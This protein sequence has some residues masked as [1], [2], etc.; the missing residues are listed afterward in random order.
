VAIGSIRA[1]ALFRS[2]RA[3]VFCLQ[4]ACLLPGA[5]HAGRE[6]VL[7]DRI[8]AQIDLLNRA[9]ARCQQRIDNDELDECD[10]NITWERRSV[11]LGEARTIARELAGSLRTH[12][13]VVKSFIRRIDTASLS[14]QTRTRAENLFAR[15]SNLG[16]TENPATAAPSAGD[17][18]MWSRVKA[19]AT[20]KAGRV[21]QWQ[22]GELETEFGNEFGILGTVG[23]AGAPLQ[24]SPGL[25]GSAPVDAV[26]FTYMVKGRPNKV[27]LPVLLAVHNR[28]CA[29]IWHKVEGALRCKSGV[30]E[31]TVNTEGSRFPSRRIWVNDRQLPTID[32]GPFSDLWE[33]D[34]RNP[35]MVR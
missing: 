17:Y 7:R 8:Q 13:L 25:S 32:Q 15:F 26:E 16:F 12:A 5:A 14:G 33:C 10:V 23:E 27:A 22:F 29:W 28:S 3:F 30:P 11:P 6:E 9:I 35:E 1:F 19:T 31:L 20:C 4:L 18:R 21:E 24:A 34:A 2:M